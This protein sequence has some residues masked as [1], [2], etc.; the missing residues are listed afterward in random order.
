MPRRSLLGRFAQ[1]YRSNATF[2]GFLDFAVF[3][4]LALLFLHPPDMTALWSVGSSLTS[5]PAAPQSV[6][7]SNT[8]TSNP[9]HTSPPNAAGPSGNPPQYAWSAISKQGPAD[10]LHLSPEAIRPQL[11]EI[12]DLAGKRQVLEAQR[13][14]ELLDAKD[15]N[16]AYLR[17]DL[18]AGQHGDLSAV[19]A[20][21][22]HAAELGHP[23]A[24]LFAAN[25]LMSGVG[26]PAD[27]ALA[28]ALLQKAYQQGVEDAGMNLAKRYFVDGE[29]GKKD[30]VKA[31]EIN[32]AL[33]N[34][35][36]PGALNNLGTQY[37]QGL[38]TAADPGRA[39]GLFRESAELGNPMAMANTGRMLTQGKGIP[40]DLAA[41]VVWLNKA[42][43]GGFI[44][45]TMFLGAVYMK[46][47]DGSPSDPLLAAQAFRK[48]A[49]RNFGPAQFALAQLYEDGH[50]LPRDLPLAYLYYGL[51]NANGERR[52][53][54]K[55]PDLEAKM[56][57]S[58]RDRAHKLLEAALP[59][60]P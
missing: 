58:D 15:P 17:G 55:L 30:Y 40:R 43:D 27:S 57:A 3:G 34:K 5:P 52:G 10:F 37:E 22:L 28:F 46:P 60:R 6:V 48:G 8:V 23:L 54:A 33:A 7:G 21:Y 29:L 38:G 19:R 2:A 53:A 18:L 35:K 9:Q 1:F 20:A 47:P 25:M 13:R 51:A 32:S 45:A 12:I 44:P 11:R 31:L 24:M 16:V 39:L 41:A 56:P 14:L 4:G 50:G 59:K 36:H 42:I 26:G 49:L